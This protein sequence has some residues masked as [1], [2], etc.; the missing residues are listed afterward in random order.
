MNHFSEHSSQAQV[1]SDLSSL[2]VTAM[3]AL[4]ESEMFDEME[5]VRA[6]VIGR[7]AALFDEIRD[8]QDAPRFTYKPMAELLLLHVREVAVSPA[9]LADRRAEIGW[10]LDAA[11]F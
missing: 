6:R 1:D 3:A 9:P 5:Q 7:G 4:Y 2:A 10:A 11:G 8:G